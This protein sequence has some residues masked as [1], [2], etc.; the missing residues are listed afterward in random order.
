MLE[1]SSEPPDL[2]LESTG[3][4]GKRQRAGQHLHQKAVA[5]GLF[6]R[7]EHAAVADGS[8]LALHPVRGLERVPQ[9]RAEIGHECANMVAGGRRPPPPPPPAANPFS[10][11]RARPPRATT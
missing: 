1:P 11:R 6:E 5:G 2:L 10:P 7:Y 9:C 4:E 3:V 8:H